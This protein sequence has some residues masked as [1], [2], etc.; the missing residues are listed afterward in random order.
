MSLDSKPKDGFEAFKRY[1]QSDA[2]SGF[3]VFILALPLSMG[4]AQASDF[5]VIYGLITAMI[6]GIVVSF[7]AGS[8]L[9][10]KGPAA[11]LIVIVAGC[12]SDFGGGE[13]GWKL[14]LGAIV[15]A[16]LV[17]VL[18]GL[19]KLGSMSDFFPLSA[20][21]GML[22]AIGI[23]IMS[24]QFHG[25]L[26]LN[27]VHGWLDPSLTDPAKSKPLVEPFEL[28]EAIPHS[29][30]NFNKTA[31]IIGLVSLCIVFGW[32]MI[33]NKI[34]KKIPAPLIVLIVA[35]PLAKFMGLDAALFVRFDK[36][37]MDILAVNV[38]FNGIHQI[39]VFV[40]YVVMFALVG[41]LE[42]LLTVKAIDMM[43]PYRRKSNANKDLIGVGIGN[44]LA[45]ILGG[46]PM[47]SEVA[48]SSA[49]VNNGATSR[50]ANFYH[51]MFVL[52]FLIFAVSFSELIPKPALSALL[53]G[54]GYKL[55]HPK[56][57]KH[58]WKIGKEQLA[59]FVGTIVVTLATDLLLGILAG[60]L[61]KMIFQL[62]KGLAF[63]DMF[64]SKIAITDQANNIFID[65]NSSLVFSNFISLSKKLE[66]LPKG[67]MVKMDVGKATMIDHSTME[68]LHHFQEDYHREG[69]EFHLVGLERFKQLS[70]HKF[71]VRI[72]KGAN[73]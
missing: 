28:F 39:G 1:W 73:T 5:P 32:P 21:H 38:D 64:K 63:S 33:K 60:I 8:P 7:L 49:N 35:I 44:T 67:K 31:L 24:K 71:A 41:S 46:L 29:L 9:T 40:K 43:D 62:T 6:G 59:I 3:L 58:M 36:N 54:V 17:Q 57:F 2:L 30:A 4:I 48:R 37:L 18:F 61:I 42:A 14:A 65:V 20:V 23:I 69:G 26:G 22:A 52:L 19:L 15:V 45:G 53:I 50:W 16:G 11:G 13:M 47:I 56:E 68:N 34:T 51:G 12:V 55:A 25:L 10:I 72:N 66:A 27:P 70:A